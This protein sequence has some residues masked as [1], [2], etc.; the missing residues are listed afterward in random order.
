VYYKLDDSDFPSNSREKRGHWVGVA[1]HVGHAMTFKILMD[2]TQKIIYR[3]NI[4]SALD[5]NSWN[6][7]M[8][9]LND[10]PI[11][12]PII[13]SR[14]DHA[15]PDPLNHGENLAVLMLIVDPNDLVGRTF[16]M[17][18]QPDGQRFRAHIVRAIE[19]HE[20]DLA[21]N[22]ERTHFLC[23]INDDQFEEIMSYN[24]ILSSLEE[25]G[26]T[27]CG[28][29]NASQHIRAL[30]HLKTRIGTDQPIMLWWSGKMGR[31]LLNPSQSLLLM[32]L[33]PVLFMH[34]ITTSW[35]LM[36]G[37]GSMGL[38]STNRNCIAWLTKL[39]SNPSARHP[40]SSMDMRYQGTLDMPSSL[41]TSAVILN[42]W[43]PLLLR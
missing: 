33:S 12:D 6:L 11:S 43:M 5:P 36:G 24:D 1:E 2:D 31:S 10:D 13:K 32:I 14:Q 4:C 26:K 23:S 30:L 21:N 28:S 18:P 20:R 15:P 42:G 3:S 38:P 25:D 19:D 27:L 16:L 40:D 34:G 7:C 17:V 41:M 22:S 35:M 37:N 39:S 8:D 9:P 29:S